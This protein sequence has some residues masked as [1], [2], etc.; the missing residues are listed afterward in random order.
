MNRPIRKILRDDAFPTLNL[1]PEDKNPRKR[2]AAENR[3]ALARK[4]ARRDM[5]ASRKEVVGVLLQGPSD[6]TK[7]DAEVQ[8]DNEG[9]DTSL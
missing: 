9:D 6:E 4:R 2:L 3:S 1:T 7:K 8:V 5:V